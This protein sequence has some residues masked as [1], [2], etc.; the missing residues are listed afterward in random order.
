MFE[1]EVAD[2][3]SGC[4]CRVSMNGVKFKLRNLDGHA[5][6]LHAACVDV[7]PWRQY[8]SCIGTSLFSIQP[9]GVRARDMMVSPRANAIAGSCPRPSAVTQEDQGEGANQLGSQ[10]F[11]QSV[12]LFSPLP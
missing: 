2:Q 7:R 4:R 1:F 10:R 5:P 9:Q 12:H 11:R 3:S 8:N 6:A